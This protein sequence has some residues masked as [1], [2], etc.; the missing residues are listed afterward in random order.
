MDASAVSMGT[1]NLLNDYHGVKWGEKEG[2]NAA[3]KALI[4]ADEKAGKK[5]L[6][7]STQ[8]GSW[9]VYNLG[10]LRTDD[11]A[12]NIQLTTITCVQELSQERL[13]SL[14]AK[15]K[16]QGYELANVV[17]HESMKPEKEDS[18]P[19]QQFGNAIFYDTK[20]VQLKEGFEIKHEAGKTGRS[21][22]GAVFQIGGTE[23]KVAVASMHLAGYWEGQPDPVKKQE[24]KQAGFEE[25]KNY[26]KQLENRVN[27]TVDAI[28][29]GG[30]FNEDANEK[31]M[32]LYRPG[33]LEGQGYKFDGNLATTEPSKNRRIDWLCCKPLKGAV[34]LTSMGLE[35]VQKQVS[36]H[37]M[38]G[39][40]VDFQ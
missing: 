25:L 36:D 2:L 8:D 31:E 26:T 19:F 11:L 28:V 6:N 15:L 32:D 22:A 9:R 12:A 38:T 39:S 40:R 16:S 10:E 7:A 27:G 23:K 17:F 18:V 14:Q 1:Y 3:G 35:S 33:F 5:T 34:Q 21:A 30:D 4:E 20:K 37:L 29:I 24:S 13:Q